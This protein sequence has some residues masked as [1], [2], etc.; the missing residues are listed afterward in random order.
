MGDQIKQQASAAQTQEVPEATYSAAEQATAYSAV[1]QGA[2][3]PAA[4]QEAADPTPAYSSAASRASVV[5]E[6]AARPLEARPYSGSSAAHSEASGARSQGR[7]TVSTRCLSRGE[8]RRERARGRSALVR[9]LG[10]AGFAI[11]RIAGTM[12]GRRV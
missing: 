9:M 1:A 11:V 12:R 6:L 8:W 2:A 5:M 3:Y 10:G 4:E 7:T